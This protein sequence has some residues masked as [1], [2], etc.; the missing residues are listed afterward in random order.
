MNISTVV[1]TADA[2][3]TMSLAVAS[4]TKAGRR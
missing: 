1:I 4:A 2:A 3:G